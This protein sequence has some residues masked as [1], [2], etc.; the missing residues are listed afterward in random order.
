MFLAASVCQFVCL[1]VCR[2]D[3]FRT[4][5]RRPSKMKNGGWRIVQKSRGSSNLGVKSQRSRS[6]GQ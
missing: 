2:Y 1:F 5:K 6:P 4:M 3:N